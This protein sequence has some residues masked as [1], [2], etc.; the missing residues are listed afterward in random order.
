VRAA[1]KAGLERLT[2]RAQEAGARKAEFEKRASGEVTRPPGSRTTG[3]KKPA[4]KTQPGTRT[5]APKA[6]TGGPS[7]APGAP[8]AGRATAPPGSGKDG[9][10]TLRKRQQQSGTERPPPR[11]AGNV[12]GD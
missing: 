5:G 9:D 6:P 8:A 11:R 3:A 1:A 10:T 12:A 2:Q 7:V 4:R